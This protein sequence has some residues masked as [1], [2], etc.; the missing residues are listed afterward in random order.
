RADDRLV[1]RRELRPECRAQAPAETAGGRPVEVAPGRA[2]ARL[3]GIEVVLVDD[4]RLLVHE[5][6]HASREPGHVDRAV[7]LDPARG[8]RPPFPPPGVLGLPAR[9]TLAHQV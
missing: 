1:R 8:R 5:L 2:E 7:T 4:D 9:P 6:A 3:R